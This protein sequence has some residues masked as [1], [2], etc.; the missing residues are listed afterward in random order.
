MSYSNFVDEDPDQSTTEPTV[1]VYKVFI[2]KPRKPTV[3]VDLHLTSGVPA[4]VHEL[5]E[6]M[7]MAIARSLELLYPHEIGDYWLFIKKQS[8]KNRFKDEYWMGF[9]VQYPDYKITFYNPTDSDARELANNL[10][11]KDPQRPR[12]VEPSL[13]DSFRRDPSKANPDKTGLVLVNYPNK[14]EDREIVLEREYPLLDSYSQGYSNDFLFKLEGF[15]EETS[16]NIGK[17]RP[18]D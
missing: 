12:L 16:K 3:I 14:I 13:E 15:G 1:L 17:V 6:N 18:V 5:N 10:K 8:S 2:R 9:H 11:D 4:N 7:D